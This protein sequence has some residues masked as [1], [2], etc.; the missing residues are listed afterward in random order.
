MNDRKE[1]LTTW[2]Q[3]RREKRTEGFDEVINNK[4]IMIRKYTL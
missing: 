4:S 1:W 2:L 3:Q